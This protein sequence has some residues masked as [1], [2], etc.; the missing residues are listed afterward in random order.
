MFTHSE[1]RILSCKVEEAYNIIA[2]V[3]E[4]PSFIPWIEEV[5]L[6]YKNDNVADFQVSVNFKVVK[7]QFSTRDT[8]YPNEKIVIQLKEGP[9]KHLYNVWEFEQVTPTTTL[10]K[11][12]IE[13][14]FKSKILGMLFSKVFIQAQKNILAAFDKQLKKVTSENK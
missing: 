11:F 8:F 10:V 2:N 3:E 14:D 12:Y 9:F 13:F 5:K 7:E 1:T 6:L 4:Y